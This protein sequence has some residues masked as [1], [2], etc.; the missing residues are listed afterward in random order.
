MPTSIRYGE[1]AESVFALLVYAH[2][3]VRE[4]V[5]FWSREFGG[6]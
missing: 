2:M 4:R 3:A 1:P 5:L 6:G